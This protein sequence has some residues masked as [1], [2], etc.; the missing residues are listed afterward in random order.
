[1]T[2]DIAVLFCSASTIQYKSELSACAGG[3]EAVE[4]FRG[5]ASPKSRSSRCGG[6]VCGN[7]I[8]AIFQ[9]FRLGWRYV[10]AHTS[11]RIQLVHCR[12]GMPWRMASHLC[13]SSSSTRR[14]VWCLPHRCTALL[15]CLLLLLLLDDCCLKWSACVDLMA[16]A[17]YRDLI[18]SVYAPF[19]KSAT[20]TVRSP[21]YSRSK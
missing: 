11:M 17:T 19:V 10:G 12:F 18:V 15:I 20:L 9:S 13:P 7:Y 2:L 3:G 6:N 16:P 5:L 1:M 14:C 8:D 4:F 21:I